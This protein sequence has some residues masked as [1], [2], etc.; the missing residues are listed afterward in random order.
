MPEIVQEVQRAIVRA[1]INT[2]TYL[3]GRQENRRLGWSGQTSRKKNIGKL[4]HRNQARSTFK[5]E[6]NTYH[7][8]NLKLHSIL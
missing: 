7:G 1:L 5:K 4:C 2:N 6:A 3:K 8:A